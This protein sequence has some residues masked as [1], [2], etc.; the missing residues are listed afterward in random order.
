MVEDSVITVEAIL[1]PQ[2]SILDPQL[3]VVRGRPLA[4]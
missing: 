2:S 4:L 1:D 3:S